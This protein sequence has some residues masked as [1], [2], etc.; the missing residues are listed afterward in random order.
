MFRSIQNVQLSHLADPRHYD[1]HGLKVD[2]QPVIDG[3]KAFDEE[4]FEPTVETM[5][6]SASANRN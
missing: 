2:G 6:L 1:F 4:I 3:D 5:I